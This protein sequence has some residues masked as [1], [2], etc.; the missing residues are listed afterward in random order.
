MKTGIMKK[1]LPK[2][3]MRKLMVEANKVDAD[4]IQAA[5]DT[6]AKREAELAPIAKRWR[7]AKTDLM[8][9]AISTEYSEKQDEAAEAY[10]AYYNSCPATTRATTS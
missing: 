2:E 6:G 4:A 9:E 3:R 7:N 5:L 10:L 1:W 8:K